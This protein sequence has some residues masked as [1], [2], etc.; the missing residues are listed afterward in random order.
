MKWSKTEKDNNF[1]SNDLI[2]DPETSK[3]WLQ[4]DNRVK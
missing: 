1:L 2:L 3:I 4:K